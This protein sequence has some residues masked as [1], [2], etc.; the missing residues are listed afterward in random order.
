MENTSAYFQEIIE[1]LCKKKYSLKQVNQLKVQLCRKHN[2]KHI[3]TSIEIMFHATPDKLK[4]LKKN[5]LAKPTRSMS[6]VAPIA[7]MTA[8]FPC[9]HGKCIFCPGGPNS[10]FGNVPQSYTGKEPSTMRAIRGN[11]DPFLIVFNRLEQFIISGHMPNKAEII[12]QGGTFPALPV[13][14]QKEFI[15]GIY[16]ALNEFSTQFFKAD[17]LRVEKIRTFFELPA[18]FTDE[19]RRVRLQKK[20]LALKKKTTFL[21]EQKRN[22]TAAI[23][24]VGLTI[25]TKPDWGFVEHGRNML[26]LG[27]TRIELGVQSVYEEPLKVCH[28]GHTIADTQKSI[29]EL[30]DLGFKLNYH[31]MLG[32]PGVTKEM[33]AVGLRQL[34]EN[35]AYKPDMLKIYPCMVM[36]GTPLYQ[37]WKAGKFIP[38][39]T[40]TAAELIAE[41]MRYVPSYC[42]V[43]RVQRDIPTYMTEAGVDRTNL[44]QYI[45]KIMQDKNIQTQEIRSREIE[46]VLYKNPELVFKKPSIKIM[47]YNASG[48]E[49]FISLEDNNALFGFVR[50]RFPSQC[51]RK[52]ITSQTAL[53]RELH[54]YGSATAFGK[55]GTVQHR[56]LGKQ[57]MKTAEKIAK[58]YG[59]NKIVVISAVGTREYYKK[60]GY[61]KEGVYMVRKI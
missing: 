23:R 38:M 30:K 12:V 8:P 53:I 49:F 39:T 36:S 35:P 27:V 29:Q 56:G 7:V 1:L 10:T 51:L 37:L 26:E 20:I 9:P 18:D 50:M 17:E 28:R 6:G 11:Y 2:M 59:K 25:E 42:R 32:L 58:K 16:Q 61:K 57:L 21:K 19:K 52:E 47:E 55:K 5:I 40:T 24:C 54:V 44:R 22:E 41:F 43:M 14:Y 4:F 13:E 3:P 34:F 31:Y 33:E 46:R 48:K 15:T 60:I 45:D